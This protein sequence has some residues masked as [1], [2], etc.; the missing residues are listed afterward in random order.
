M[1][2]TTEQ[3]GDHARTTNITSTTNTTTLNVLDW[4]SSPRKYSRGQNLPFHLK[5]VKRFLTNVK[6]PSGYHLPILVNSLDEEC[7]LE[8]FAHPY[9]DEDE[10]D[11]GIVTQLVSQIFDDKEAE[12]SKLVRLLE[13]KQEP[14]ESL[15]QFLGRIRTCR[16]V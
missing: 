13:M 5:A 11:F 8:L 9:Y 14:T 2:G 12:L 15:I 6:A 10:T 4:I 16:S 3:S 7:Q 1:N